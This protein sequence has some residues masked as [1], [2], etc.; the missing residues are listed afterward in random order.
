MSS[1][2]GLLPIH[3]RSPYVKKMLHP[4]VIFDKHS[5]T[6]LTV[7]MF[8]G[9]CRVG[10]TLFAHVRTNTHALT[11]RR[12]LY[13]LGKK[14]W[15][16]LDVTIQDRCREIHSDRRATNRYAID[17]TVSMGFTPRLHQTDIVGSSIEKFAS[18][19]IS[20]ENFTTRENRPYFD[21]LVTPLA[22][23]ISSTKAP[24]GL[25]KPL[26]VSCRLCGVY[27]MPEGIWQEHFCAEDHR[28]AVKNVIE[29]V[30][31]ALDVKAGPYLL[32]K[33]LSGFLE[34]IHAMNADLNLVFADNKP[35]HCDKESLCPLGPS[36]TPETYPLEGYLTDSMFMSE[37]ARPGVYA[38]RACS[39]VTMSHARFASHREYL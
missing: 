10:H 2:W 12:I 30:N 5:N 1:S 34:N 29:T 31:M 4:Q 16:T 25:S 3:E 37:C 26:G 23:P 13:L 8:C 36:L 22:H 33:N 19:F 18:M 11:K 14:R 17:L 39:F 24:S 6:S 35:V 9:Y 27:R 28:D 20:P 38:C 15:K 32:E 7:C 21:Y